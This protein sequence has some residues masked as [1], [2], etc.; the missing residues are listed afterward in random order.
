MA[1]GNRDSGRTVTSKVLS[2]FTTFEYERRPLGL[3]EIA[4]SADLP[5]STT[6]RLLA[7]L[8]EAAFISR[9]SDGR[10]QLGLHIWELAQN[11]GRQ[12]RETAS[13]FV[14]ELFSLT[15]ETAQLAIRDGNEALFIDR[16][17]GTKRVPRASRL[18]GRIP[19]H[20]S[21][22][23]KAILAFEYP[24]V[25]EA[26]LDLSLAPVTRYTIVHPKRL[27]TELDLAVERG[28]ATTMEEQRLG[29]CSIAVPVFHTG[30]VG[31]GLGLVMRT[32]QSATMERHLPVLRAISAH[33][34]KATAHIPLETLLSSHR[35]DVRRS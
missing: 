31:A 19:L 8:V 5:V 33:I 22:V 30:R 34:E 17:Y 29:A 3:S 2:I 18:G 1:G 25:R 6:H 11:V 35:D 15:G 32:D 28:F 4:R 26:Y 9:T 27:A 24:W 21:G 12:L 13:P 20:T 10:Y 14:Q 16:V 23:G 7:E